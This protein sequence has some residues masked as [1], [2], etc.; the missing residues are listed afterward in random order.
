LAQCNKSM[1]NKLLS[2]SDF[3]VKV[4]GKSIELLQAI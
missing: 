3:E 2:K 1:Q 4:K